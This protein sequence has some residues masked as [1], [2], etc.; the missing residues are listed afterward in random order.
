MTYPKVLDLDEGL[1]Q[2]ISHSLNVPVTRLHNFTSL[3]DDLHLDPVDI[4]L[5]IAALESRFS[6]YLSREEVASI[7]TVGDANACFSQK[8]A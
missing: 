8:A 6:C 4:T 2:T 5:L 3:R 1:L 7:E